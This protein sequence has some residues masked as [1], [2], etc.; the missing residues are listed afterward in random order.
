MLLIQGFTERLMSQVGV[1][2]SKRNA[3]NY[4]LFL[5]E[6]FL[7]LEASEEMLRSTIQREGARISLVPKSTGKG[8]L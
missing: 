7:C 5:M 8:C 1:V 2:L 6:A 3:Q 4:R